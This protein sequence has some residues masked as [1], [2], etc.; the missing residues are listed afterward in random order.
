MKTTKQIRAS[1]ELPGRDDPEDDGTAHE[2]YCVQAAGWAHGLAGYYPDGDYSSDADWCYGTGAE[3]HRLEESLDDE[4]MGDVFKLYTDAHA[5][6]LAERERRAESGLVLIGSFGDV[7]A[8]EYGGGKVFRRPDGTLFLEYTHGVETEAGARDLHLDYTDEA[9][10]DVPLTVYRRDVELDVLAD[11][12]WVNWRSV[13]DSIGLPLRQLH[14]AAVSD[15]VM[16]RVSC[17]EAVAGHWGW[18][19]LDPY[20]DTM[21]YAELQRSWGDWKEKP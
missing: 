6:G 2:L 5:E 9:A 12:D 21:T 10:E 19:D 11:L 16:A 8:E 18:H 1:F 4:M 17:Y 15:A 14:Q 20:P 3:I 13:A 7:S